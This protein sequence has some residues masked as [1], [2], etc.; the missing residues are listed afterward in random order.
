MNRLQ[1][2]FTN[3]FPAQ[4]AFMEAESRQ[5]FLKCLRCDSEISIWDLGGI[6]WKAKGNSRNYMKC[7]KCKKRSWQQMY[8]KEADPSL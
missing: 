2:F 6:K 1:K 5:W 4:A 7:P 3:L 8:K